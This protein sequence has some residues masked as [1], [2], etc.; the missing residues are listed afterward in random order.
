MKKFYNILKDI[1]AIIGVIA[2]IAIIW[3]YIEKSS[4]DISVTPSRIGMYD[5]YVDSL[6]TSGVYV[7]DSASFV[8]TIYQDT[9][10]ARKIKE[11]FR[12]DTLYSSTS[13][14]WTKALAIGKFVSGNIP[15]AN[16]KEWPQE[17]N[18]IGLWEYTKNVEPAFN[19]RLHSIF[20]FELLL[21]AGIP[22][23]FV[24]CFPQD[25]NDQDCHVVN[26]IWL[27]EMQKW[28]MLDTDMGGHYVSDKQGVPLSLREIREHYICGEKMS[29]HP[30]FGKGKS[31]VDDYYSYMAKNTYWFSCWGSLSYS[32][33]DWKN[34][35]VVRDSYINLVPSG[36]EPFRVGGGNTITTNA[37]LFW[38]EPKLVIPSTE[39]QQ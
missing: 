8:F 9:V 17:I 32:Q 6:R 38:S 39:Q 34:E 36:F 11:Y 29:M 21:A 15:H 20:T 31:K 35:D 14:T 18:A 26:E 4:L 19:C 3:F 30:S 23:R 22:A 1:F 37:D 28:A 27:P 16:Q 7:T 25:E 24:T 2:T 13:D 5:E 10:Q 33:E 12:L